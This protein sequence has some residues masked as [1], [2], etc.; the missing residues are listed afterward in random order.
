M[1]AYAMLY[2][3]YTSNVNIITAEDGS[4]DFA[5]SEFNPKTDILYLEEYLKEAYDLAQI[6]SKDNGYA[7]FVHLVCKAIEVEY[8]RWMYAPG[9]KLIPHNPE[10]A[11]RILQEAAKI[12]NDYI[13][14][15]ALHNLD[16]AHNPSAYDSPKN[17]E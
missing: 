1:M 13:S 10:E 11:D 14:V 5:D 12:D 7:P 16:R 6:V 3:Q 8:A 4:Q 9:L 2:D 15:H 17:P